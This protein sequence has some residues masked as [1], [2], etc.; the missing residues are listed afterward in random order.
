MDV[1]MSPNPVN[2]VL[3]VMVGGADEAVD[4]RIYNARGEEALPAVSGLPPSGGDFSMNGLP[5]GIYFVTVQSGKLFA[6]RKVVKQ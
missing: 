6:T 5:P 4:C 1:A 3:S 2:D